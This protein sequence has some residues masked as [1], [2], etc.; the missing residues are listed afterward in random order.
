MT[1]ASARSRK[2]RTDN[3]GESGEWTRRNDP[4]DPDCTCDVCEGRAPDYKLSTNQRLFVRDAEKQGF[5]VD[6]TYSGR[7]MYGRRCPYIEV[8]GMGEFGTKAKTAWDN[9]GFDYVIYARD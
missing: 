1:T 7:F 4:H 8:H 3:D 2:Y 5:K 9:M 6:Y